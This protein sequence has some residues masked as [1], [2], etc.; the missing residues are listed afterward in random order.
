MLQNRY[1]VFCIQL[2]GT[3]TIGQ[4]PLKIQFCKKRGKPNRAWI[5]MLMILLNCLT[6]HNSI[7]I[8][9]Y[10]D[11]YHHISESMNRKIW[12]YVEHTQHE[13]YVYVVHTQHTVHSHFRVIKD[14][15][16]LDNTMSFSGFLTSALACGWVA[17]YGISY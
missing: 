13:Q 2:F 11:L 15:V 12:T 5:C 4:V 9:F 17:V 7:Q 8:R 16:A 3:V 10:F 1:W 14:I 6:K